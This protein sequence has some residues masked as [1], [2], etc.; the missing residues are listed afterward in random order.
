MD[1]KKPKIVL[2]FKIPSN[3]QELQDILAVVIFISKFCL[4]LA[5]WLSTLVELQGE[6]ACW[7]WADT[8]TMAVVKKK[9][10]LNSQ[11]ILKQLDH[12]SEE[13]KYLVSNARNIGLGSWIGQV[14]LGL[15]RPSHFILGNSALYS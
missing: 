1:S 12:F 2:D 9:E 8:H 4:E 10:L 13:P 14:E 5:S 6:N 15:I 11:H 7:R 3:C